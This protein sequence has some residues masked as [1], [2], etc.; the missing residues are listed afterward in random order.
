LNKGRLGCQENGIEIL[1]TL[2]GHF[3]RPP[4]PAWAGS[5][6]AEV[7]E[8]NPAPLNAFIRAWAERYKGKI[9]YFEILNEPRGQHKDLSIRA[10]VDDTGWSRCGARVSLD[11]QA[12]FTR[13]RPTGLNLW[14]HDQ[15]PADSEADFAI[16]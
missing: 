8:K 16:R 4:V 14:S 9:H 7:V 11:A 13:P 2:G 1:A 5:T 12:A 6:L 3:D 10:Y 15:P